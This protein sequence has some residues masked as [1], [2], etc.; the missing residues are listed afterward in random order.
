M[1][2][3]EY[4]RIERKLEG[5]NEGLRKSLLITTRRTSTTHRHSTVTQRKGLI[6]QQR[7]S[8]WL[9]EGITRTQRKS[10]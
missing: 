5:T 6:V 1:E 9:E 7:P 10:R 2:A 3:G 8:I 4:R